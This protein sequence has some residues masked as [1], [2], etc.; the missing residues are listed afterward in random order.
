MA[1]YF[2]PI[3]YTPKDFEFQFLLPQTP[4]QLHHESLRYI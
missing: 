3:T 4:P 2:I 1:G